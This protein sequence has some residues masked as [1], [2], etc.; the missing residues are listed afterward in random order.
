METNNRFCNKVETLIPLCRPERA[1]APS[2]AGGVQRT[3]S[4]FDYLST[5]FVSFRSLVLTGERWLCLF[6]GKAV[7][8]P[9]T[10]GQHALCKTLDPA[11]PIP[12]WSQKVTSSPF[13]RFL[14]DLAFRWASA[15]NPAPCSTSVPLHRQDRSVGTSNRPLA[16]C[17]KTAQSLPGQAGQCKRRPRSGRL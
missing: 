16:Q 1:H 7:I 12:S 5:V 10:P 13:L 3:P 14:G 9:A 6:E 8:I 4:S 15:S 17:Q 11:Q 2:G